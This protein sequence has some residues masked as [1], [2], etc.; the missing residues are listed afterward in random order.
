MFGLGNFSR[1]D[2][3]E[4]RSRQRRERKGKA[5]PWKNFEKQKGPA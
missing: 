5:E 3:G 2:L 1:F 4:F